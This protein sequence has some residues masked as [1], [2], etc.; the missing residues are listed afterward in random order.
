MKTDPTAVNRS[1][2]P[3]HFDL[4]KPNKLITADEGKGRLLIVDDIRENREI[5]RRR[6]ERHG[7]HT[8]E[9]N[10]GVEA[11]AFLES[12]T[13]DLVLLDIMMPDLSGLEVLA[14]IRTKHAPGMLPVIMV[15]AKSQS[16][17]VVQALRGGANDYITKPVDFSIAL[18]RV[19]T[20]LD[21]KR[22]E[23]KI[24]HINEKLSEA[25][26]ALKCQIVAHTNDLVQSN[27]EL[28]SEIEQ[29]EKS[30]AMVEHLAH[31]DT[32][33]SLGN[34]LLFHK[35]LNDALVHRQLYGS[36][37]AVLFIDLDGFKTVNDT[38]GH[39]TGDS[40]LKLVASR[41]KGEL[42]EN[43]KIGRLGG[44]EFALIQ[45]GVEQPKEAIALAARLIE[46]LKVPFIIDGQSLTIGASIG[47]AV[48]NSEYYD[49]TEL[50]R[51]A[52]LAM[53]QAK[54]EG[55]GR[56]RIFE[57]KLDQKRKGQVC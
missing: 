44:D 32:L 24:Q 38:L 35:Q 17:D 31:H 51:A 45:S 4:P 14:W 7:F 33:T 8:K 46:V 19:I 26:Q 13:F 15:T 36:D 21:R 16:E 3:T 2:E 48:A 54:A 10:G 57:S 22:A 41:L 47:I 12:E 1:S 37:L 49:S 6:F 34:R 18:A 20:Q 52:D 40:L 43:D 27:V 39:G 11:L 56:F 29:R 5:L 42:Q 23:E 25:N 50:L 30:H 55:R 9:A 28:R 53:Y